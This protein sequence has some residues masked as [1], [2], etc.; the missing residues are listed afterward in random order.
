MTRSHNTICPMVG[1]I[2][3]LLTLLSL[4]VLSCSNANEPAPGVPTE[5]AQAV[6][7]KPEISAESPSE[8][9]DIQAMVGSNDFP[10]GTP[11][12]PLLLFSGAQKVSDAKTVVV[13]AF[14]LSQDPPKAGWQGEATNYSDYSVPYWVVYPELPSVGTW[15]LLTEI[16]KKD[17]SKTTS[18][19]VIEVTEASSVP[20]IGS[21]PPA[22]KNRTVAS[23]PD[24]AKLTTSSKPNPAFYQTTIAEAMQNGKPSIIVFA[25]PGYCQ[26]AMCSPVLSSA[27][28]VQAEF[29]ARANFIHIEVFKKPPPNAVVDDTMVEWQ[30]ESEPWTFV[31]DDKGVIAAHFSGPVSPRELRVAV[32]DV[33]K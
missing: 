27:E 20:K 19:L 6:A 29:A 1:Q 33:L 13:T 7:T 18:Q 15:G 10:A 12:V 32:E 5:S 30:L 26:T 21:R 4:M 14:D 31:L 17:G 24:L 3:I 22:S 8:V 23:E 28:E 16:V 2:V 9:S 25:T 11:R